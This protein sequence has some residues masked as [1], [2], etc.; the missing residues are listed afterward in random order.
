MPCQLR[1]A[2]RVATTSSKELRPSLASG[3][4]VEPIGS[5]STLSTTRRSRTCMPGFL[6]SGM[7][8]RN[9]RSTATPELS[10]YP[11]STTAG[12]AA[13]TKPLGETRGKRALCI[14]AVSSD[15]LSLSPDSKMVGNTRP[16]WPLRTSMSLRVTI[17]KG[18]AVP[19]DAAFS[20]SGKG[21]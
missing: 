17:A 10:K 15:T 12:P 18:R 1:A 21:A 20:S 13:A 19:T 4:G 6:C 16:C 14:A 7:V 2:I 11:P 3:G 9:W 8:S 5:L